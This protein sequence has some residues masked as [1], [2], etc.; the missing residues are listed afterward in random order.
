MH[1]IK[2]EIYINGKKPA[3]NAGF[4]LIELIVVVAGLASLITIASTSFQK[5]YSD[6]E[7]DEVQA[8]LNST[9]AECLKALGNLRAPENYASKNINLDNKSNNPDPTKNKDYPYLIDA[10]DD[11]LLARNGYR[12]NK[13]FQSC[14]YLQIDPIDADSNTHPSIGFGIYNGKLTKFGISPH[15][16]QKH[17]ARVMCE[18]WAGDQCSSQESESYNNFFVYMTNYRYNREKCELDFRKNLANNKGSNILVRWDSSNSSTCNGQTSVRNNNTNYKRACAL[19]K[20]NKTAYVYDDK[21]TGYTKESQDSAQT[22]ACS[23]NISK[24]INGE[25]TANGT[26][27]DGDPKKDLRI[28]ECRESVSICR[29][30]QVAAHNFDLCKIESTIEKCKIDLEQRIRTDP[31]GTGGPYVVGKGAGKN[32]TDLLG[33]PPCGQEVWVYNKAIYYEKR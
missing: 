17:A 30:S 31:K 7:N 15:D 25:I 28:P 27:Y 16:T 21:F 19:S 1:Y 29:D 18:R 22:I 13:A 10:L 23:N 5:I 11:R 14:A 24:Y 20:C 32:D 9:A 12:I 4:S 8:H 3:F 2:C 33:L 6:L 26:K